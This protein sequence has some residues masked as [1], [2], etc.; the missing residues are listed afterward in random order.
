MKAMTTDVTTR[1]LI[2]KLLNNIPALME[3]H[4]VPGLSLT[5]IRDADI[6]WN[7]AFGVQSNISQEL[8]TRLLHLKN[9]YAKRLK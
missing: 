3:K 6:F 4:N 9:R 5:L 7:L 8:V 2:D 1:E